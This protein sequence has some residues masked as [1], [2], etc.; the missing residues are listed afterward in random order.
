VK[1]TEAE[2]YI[3]ERLHE[4][5]WE[6]AITE[7]LK[8]ARLY[9]G[10]AIMILTDEDAGLK[11]PLGKFTR[12]TELA[13]F[14]RDCIKWHTNPDLAVLGQSYNDED[15]LVAHKSRLFFISNGS[16]SSFVASASSKYG[17]RFGCQ[18]GIPEYSR[19]KRSL[20][21]CMKSHQNGAAL[22]ERAAQ[23]VYKVRGL[24]ELLSMPEGE[25]EVVKRLRM[26]DL[27]R[28]YMNSIA[29]DAEG[30][31]YTFQNMS[32]SGVRDLINASCTMLSS[33][34]GIPQTTL[35]GRSPSGQNSTG[36]SDLE[37]YYN[38]ISRI[39]KTMVAPNLK[40]ML[41]LLET[42][43]PSVFEGLLVGFEF[44]QLWSLSELEKAELELKNAQA[45]KIRAE[46]AKIYAE[47][48]VVSADEIKEGLRD[49]HGFEVERVVLT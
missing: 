22:I 21:D 27:S 47:I 20:A 25:D 5:D 9:G 28:G 30:E 35:F 15:N 46:A 43:N 16:S 49:E 17:S 29:I 14:G 23:A 2:D 18:W 31:D 7:A 26:I 48:G 10:S 6:E 11:T 37:N 41:E 8:L 4:L 42:E 39:Q 36:I 38:F 3:K 1:D 45:E 33:V 12:I 13:V 19:I 40:H 32:L 24:A 34:T 44:N